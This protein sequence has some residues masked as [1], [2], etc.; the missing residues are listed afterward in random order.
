MKINEIITEESKN[1]INL[2]RGTTQGLPNV[3][4]YPELSGSTDPYLAYRFGVQ[5][6]SSPLTDNNHSSPT[7]SEFVTIGYSDADQEILD[8]ARKAFGIKRT[9]HG[10]KGSDEL[11]G[12]GVNSPTAPKKKN[13]Y[14]V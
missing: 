8:H 2:R 12:I 14:G 11:N 7:G 6:A 4:S 5:L 3:H 1:K 9:V 10:S 13:K